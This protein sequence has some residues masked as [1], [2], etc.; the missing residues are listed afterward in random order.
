MIVAIHAPDAIRIPDDTTAIARITVRPGDSLVAVGTDAQ[1]VRLR[2][3][4]T[5]GR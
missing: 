1:L 3:Y 4:V 2:Q 5:G